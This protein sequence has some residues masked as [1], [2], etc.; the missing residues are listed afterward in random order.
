MA[1]NLEQQHQLYRNTNYS[2]SCKRIVNR[3]QWVH[4]LPKKRGPGTS[5]VDFYIF[6]G[7]KS[8]PSFPG[9][10]MAT[11]NQSVVLHRRNFP[12]YYLLKDEVVLREAILFRSVLGGSSQLVNGK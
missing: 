5:P 2:G 11:I 6:D 4:Y 1:Y 8:N 12:Y 10:V 7:K 3:E 9:Y